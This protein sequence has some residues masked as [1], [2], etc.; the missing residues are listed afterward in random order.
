MVDYQWWSKKLK[1]IFAP[2]IRFKEDFER[3]VITYI[4]Y[5]FPSSSHDFRITTSICIYLQRKE[6]IPTPIN[7]K[8]QQNNQG[9]VVPGNGQSNQLTPVP[10]K[11]V[12][13]LKIM[14]M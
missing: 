10:D 9:S 2:V 13:Y 12:F 6:L 14:D 3:I 4:G 8:Q 11:N 5:L 1:V 7:N